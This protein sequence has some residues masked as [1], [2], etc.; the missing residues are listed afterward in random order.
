L[1]ARYLRLNIPIAVS[2]A[3]SFA[4]LAGG[5]YRHVDAAKAVAQGSWFSGFIPSDLTFTDAARSALFDAVL[6]GT[7]PL[8]PPVWTLRVEF[9][10]SIFV[11]LLH[12]CG[13]RGRP[14]L[15]TAIAA[16]LV[17]RIYG[18][19]SIYFIAILGGALLNLVRPS[20]MVARVCVVVGLY[21][22]AFQYGHALYD[23]LPIARWD[24]K[25]FYN[26]V[27]ACCLMTGV[28]GG[29]GRSFLD[30]R[31]VQFLGR[32]SFALYLMHFIVLCSIGSHL[33]LALY[34]TVGL[35]PVFVLY[36]GSCLAISVLFTR[37]VDRPAIAA[38]HAFAR[39]L[40][41]LTNG[42]SARDRPRDDGTT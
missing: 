35:V 17:D 15:A 11:L 5:G 23:F 13:P 27:G 29:V 20:A 1:W 32:Q 25:S 38:S 41:S 34:D 3:L 6:F 42:G 12:L 10:G 19:E 8:N 31:P 22:G 30:S 4:I 2:I 39:W 33:Y 21:F 28:I 14:V 40:F 18:S 37:L 26:V 24:A 9:L 16:L 7:G 36:L